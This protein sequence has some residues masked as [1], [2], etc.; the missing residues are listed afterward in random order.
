MKWSSSHCAIALGQAVTPAERKMGLA[1]CGISLLSG[2]DTGAA[3]SPFGPR[4]RTY[5][6]RHARISATGV[7][8]HARHGLHER[9]LPSA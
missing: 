5:R 7:T 1:T 2:F 6:A 3:C 9:R 4:V 8:A